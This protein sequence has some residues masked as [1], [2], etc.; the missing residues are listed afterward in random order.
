MSAA[1]PA[2]KALVFAV[3]NSYGVFDVL[4]YSGAGDDEK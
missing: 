4:N 1:V 2:L 3:P